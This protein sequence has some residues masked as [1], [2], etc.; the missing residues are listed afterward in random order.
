L[1]VFAPRAELFFGIQ[2]G[3]GSRRQQ[4][5]SHQSQLRIRLFEQ[6]RVRRK[7]STVPESESGGLIGNGRMLPPIA[8]EV[9]TLNR[10]TANAHHLHGVAMPLQVQSFA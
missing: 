10:L 2:L 9:M 7:N 1:P 8:P 4:S 5:M 6:H 3:S